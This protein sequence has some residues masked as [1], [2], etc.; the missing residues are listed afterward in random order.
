MRLS[1]HHPLTHTS[2]GNAIAMALDNSP[3]DAR[4]LMSGILQQGYSLGYVIAA[5]ANLGVGGGQN[6]WK[7]V[8]WIGAALSIAVGLVRCLFPESKQFLEARAAGKAQA[9][10][11]AFWKE[12]K[13]MLAKEWKMCVYCIILMTWF[14]CKPQFCYTYSPTQRIW[15]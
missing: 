3:A 14:N 12:T 13:V 4:G 8:F 9:N 6:S 7:T 1:Q 15:C 5:C 10:P 11:S 2:Y